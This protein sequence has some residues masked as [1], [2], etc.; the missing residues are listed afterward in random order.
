MRRGHGGLFFIRAAIGGLML[1]WL[2][3]ISAEAGTTN[4]LVWQAGG[5]RVSADLHG[6]PLLSLLKTISRQTGWKIYV[7]PTATRVASTK[8]AN[9]PVGDALKMLLGDLNFALVP[10]TNGPQELYV[11]STQM[12][13]ATRRVGIGDDKAGV[14]RHVPNELII[15]VKRGVD[16]EALAKSL[17]AKIIGGDAKLGIYRLQFD[18]EADTDSAMASLRVHDRF[19][20]L[21]RKNQR[22]V[23]GG[24]IV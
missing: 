20:L 15:R 13:N 4:T 11:F 12:K 23:A 1:A 6:E 5:A 8:F 10:Q 7:E 19:L 16:V 22:V 17:G 14:A 21:R 2:L 9:L 24:V 3:A 18:N